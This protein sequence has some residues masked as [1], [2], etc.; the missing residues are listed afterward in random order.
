MSVSSDRSES[1]P[2]LGYEEEKVSKRPASISRSIRTHLPIILLL[3]HSR[4]TKQVQN[5]YLCQQYLIMIR[6]W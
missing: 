4:L 5:A 2:L 6:L 3:V 1:T